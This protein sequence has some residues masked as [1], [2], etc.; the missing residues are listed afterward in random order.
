VAILAVVLWRMPGDA[1]HRS[2]AS[3][4]GAPAAAVV[5]L[6]ATSDGIDVASEDPEFYAWLATRDL[7]APNG[8]G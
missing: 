4:D 2:A 3:A 7:P 8:A 1:L 6:L 5:E